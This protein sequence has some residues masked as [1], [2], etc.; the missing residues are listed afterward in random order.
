[1]KKKI[2][3][4]KQIPE[5]ENIPSKFLIPGS[6]FLAIISTFIIMPFDNLKT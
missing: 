6:F 4:V 3:E 5:K 1:M 2:R